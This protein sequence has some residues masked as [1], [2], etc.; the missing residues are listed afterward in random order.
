MK[1][2][3]WNVIKN[4]NIG[5]ITMYGE[6]A[7]ESWWGDEVT[8]KKF[9]EDLDALGDVSQIK[10]YL[11]SPG[12]DVFAGQQIHSMLK[13][14]KAEVIIY[15]ES[16]AASIASVICSAGDKVIMP[17]N[18][19]QML[20][21]PMTGF[22]GNAIEFRKIADDLDKIR[23]S[24]IEAYLGKSSEL[25]REKLIEIMDA[26][27][28]LTAKECKELGLCDEVVEA[29]EIAAIST[30]FLNKYKN[31]PEE[32]IKSTSNHATE[33]PQQTEPQQKEDPKLTVTVNV[34]KET[35]KEVVDEAIDKEKQEIE[36]ENLNFEIDLI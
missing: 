28:W 12:G 30:E 26:E 25:T 33:D 31:A 7:S 3:F 18:S 4:G 34:D 36:I 1:K 16:L 21:N 23:E 20:H 32:F 35:M 8:P 6:I 11:S 13:R 22:Y 15:V 9:K 2:K 24:L 17:S 14:N 5:E 27:T 29:K 19:M 10:V